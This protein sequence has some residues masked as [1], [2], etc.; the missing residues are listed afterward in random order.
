MP[1][2]CIFHDCPYSNM[3]FKNRAV[4]TDH[5]GLD[6]GFAPEWEAQFCQLCLEPTARGREAVSIH[7]ARHM[8]EI[9]LAALP[10]AVNSDANSEPR[11]GQVPLRI[12]DHEAVTEL[13][14]SRLERV[15]QLGCRSVAKAWV[16]ALQPRKQ[17]IYPYR[18][19]GATR[20]S[21]WPTDVP[22]VEPDHLSKVSESQ[23]YLQ[24]L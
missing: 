7:L 20:P 10:R 21:W 14:R 5:L 13:Y 6:H 22:H 18:G 2:V 24:S 1:Y 4:W 3:P 19:P 16:K 12:G 11:S 15:M 8:E 17:T 23:S 9:A